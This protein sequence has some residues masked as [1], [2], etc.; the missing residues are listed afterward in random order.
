MWPNPSKRLPSLET[1]TLGEFRYGR[2]FY[3]PTGDGMPG[4]LQNL[5]VVLSVDFIPF[6]NSAS[7]FVTAFKS[8]GGSGSNVST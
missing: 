1:E 7:C 6:P 4:S 3:A 8:T 2:R 5:A